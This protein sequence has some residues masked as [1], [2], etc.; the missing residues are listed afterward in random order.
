MKFVRMITRR[1]QEAGRGSYA[2]G[3]SVIFRVKKNLENYV[4]NLPLSL[5]LYFSYAKDEIAETGVI[6]EIVKY[7]SDKGYSV[8]VIVI[9]PRIKKLKSIGY[10][11]DVVENIQKKEYSLPELE[12]VR[13][14][15]IPY[16]KPIIGYFQ[17]WKKVREIEKKHGKI[18]VID[19][20][21]YP[22]ALT[23]S[24]K[25]KIILS[26]H[27]WELL[28]PRS[29]PLPCTFSKSIKNCKKSVTTTPHKPLNPL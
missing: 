3:F 22:F 11:N 19:I 10:S 1:K 28:C 9:R 14:Y 21:T 6:P 24:R 20:H 17:I 5:P 25:R 13:I 26:I 7:L 16:P 12:N 2:P 15:N 29:P 27:F 23:F 18:D 4:R 8:D